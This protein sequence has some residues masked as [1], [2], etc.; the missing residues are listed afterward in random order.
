MANLISS[1]GGIF[2]SIQNGLASPNALSKLQP[3][4]FRGIGFLVD[5][6]S[7]DGGR[8]LVTHE[9]PNTNKRYVEDLGELQETFTINGLVTGQ[10]YAQKRDSLIAALK[11]P[12]RGQLIHPM[13][14]AVTVVAKP[15]SLNESMNEFGVAKFT[16]VFEKSDAATFPSASSDNTALINSQNNSLIGTIGNDI[17]AIF[18]VSNKS[19]SNFLSAQ[20]IL[21]GVGAVFGI[22]ANNFL[23]VASQISQ[24]NSNLASFNN[25]I[26]KNIQNPSNLVFDFQNLFGTYS[27]I[28]STPANQYS[29]LTGLFEYGAKSTITVA[30]TPE[31]KQNLANAQ[32]INSAMNISALGYAYNIIPQ[33]TFTTDVDIQTVQNQ[34]QTQFNYIINNNNASDDTIQNLKVS[35]N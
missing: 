9:Y 26:K 22:N 24:F 32:I 1:I 6:A 21:Q 35:I 29:L 3:A 5:S 28:G 18:A 20:T 2:S 11:Q 30:T 17:N 10:N 16:M 23:K 12:D 13:F 25:N 31:A 4:S 34:L 7:T 14:G 15:Y 8:K 33:L 19:P 27:L